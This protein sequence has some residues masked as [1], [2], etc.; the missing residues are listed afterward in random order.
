MNIVTQPK[1]NAKRLPSGAEMITAIAYPA[2]MSKNEAA[3]FLA[4][5]KNEETG[6]RAEQTITASRNVMRDAVEGYVRTLDE[7]SRKHDVNAMFA[8][9]HEIRGLAETA[10]LGVAGRMANGLCLY[11]DA[12]DGK[13]ADKDTVRLHVEAI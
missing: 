2:I 6:K 4:N 12:L 3:H 13:P 7:A 5:L 10:G 1:P 9:A 8:Q 11:F